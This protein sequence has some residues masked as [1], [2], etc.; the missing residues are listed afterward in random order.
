MLAPRIA[1][2]VLLLAPA[3]AAALPA[4][5]SR[6]LAGRVVDRAGDPVSRA[7]VEVACPPDAPPVRL[8]A[9]A[10]GRLL[11]P[12]PAGA[13]C[14]LVAHPPGG[15]LPESALDLAAGAPGAVTLTLPLDRFAEGIEVR[16]NYS[17]DALAARTIRESA[18]RDAGEALAALPGLAMVRKGG[19]ANDVVLR[20]RKGDDLALRIDGHALHGACPN[21]MDPPAFHVDFAEIEA[22]EVRRGPNDAATGGLAGSIEILSRKPE[23]G[24]RV[25]A[26][27]AAGAF[28]YVAPSADVAWA[29]DR[30]SLDAGVAL[31]RGDPY[32]D[33]DGRAI[34]ELLPLTAAAAYRAA[35]RATRAFDV[36]TAW[37]G[38]GFI[39][40]PGH[41]LEIKATRQE[42]D[43]QLYPYLQ[44][45]ARTDDATRARA[46]YRAERSAGPV[47]AW[48]ASLGWSRVDHRMDDRL[49]VSSATAPRPYSMATDAR[50]EDWSA[51][52]EATFASGPRLGLESLRREWDAATS[53]AMMGYRAQA[54]LPGTRLDGT[55]LFA[56][57]ARPLPRRFHL[58]AGLRVERARGTA[59]S[60]LADADL[61]YAY[62]RTRATAAADTLTSAH[63]G[64]VYAPTDHLE[65]SAR[66]GSA[67]RAPDPQERY[68]ALRRMGTDWVGNPELAPPRQTELDL[69]TRFGGERWNVELSAFAALLNDAVTVVNGPRL[70][71]VPGVMNTRARTFV[72]HDSR[73]W[74]AE[75][76]FSFPL[77]E[78]LALSGSIAWLRATR[79]VAPELG[80]VDRDLPEISPLSG[81][82]ALR[83]EPGRWYA[84]LEGVA[85]A[86]QTRVDSGLQETPTPAW[87]I[88]NLRAGLELGKFWLLGS[89]ENLFDR[90]YREHLSYQRDPFRTGVQ[91]PEP[92]RSFTL[93][94]R[95]RG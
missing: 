79:D 73:L 25:D 40:R 75:G 36:G 38:A 23:P 11:A 89:L 47:R 92:G 56:E 53:L 66:L 45:D 29:D 43:S 84:E 82:L 55:A 6:S 8:T 49:R 95:Y 93:S 58:E 30:L 74:G 85:A 10:L 64:L 72:N 19:L 12:L 71:M 13:D 70:E 80:I 1:A 15:G 31:R 78:R 57:L 4:V 50:S 51:R 9:D 81:R 5:E 26:G 44:M 52:G 14:R 18:A 88:A 16:T 39:A 35:A 83:Y 69:G 24:L 62:H 77:A 76:S 20:G 27:V 67:E 41:R 32:E 21:R 63:L 59:D 54:S 48:V 37:F 28:G 42:A 34:T 3:L 60:A 61:Y 2:T 86:K 17:R 91:V 94:V 7:V 65:L 33:G 46:T 90:T 68:F 87:Q 22:I